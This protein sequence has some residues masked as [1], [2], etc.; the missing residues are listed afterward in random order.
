MAI[1][2]INVREV[3]NKKDSILCNSLGAQCQRVANVALP[4]LAMYKPF[5]FAMG[6]GSGAMKVFA[7]V[8]N[9]TAAIKSGDKKDITFQ[10]I[11]TA[12]TV[13]SLASTLI[14]HPLGMLI[15]T[16]NDV[17]L[18]TFHMVKFIH[19]GDYQKAAE[20]GFSILSN[21]VYLSVMLGGGLELSIASVALQILSGIYQSRAEFM[22][23]NYLEALGHVAM[24]GIKSHQMA[25]QIQTLQS[26]WKFDALL[27]ELSEKQKA[28]EAKPKPTKKMLACVQSKALKNRPDIPE[29]VLNI[30][31]K[32]QQKNTSLLNYLKNYGTECT[33]DDVL[34]LFKHHL[35][36]PDE[37]GKICLELM[38]RNCS[39]ELIQISLPDQEFLA[40]NSSFY[41]EIYQMSLKKHC[42]SK[43]VRLFVS[44]YRSIRDCKTRDQYFL[45][46]YNYEIQAI[47]ANPG[48]CFADF[49]KS[50]RYDNT[51]LH[52]CIKKM[53][54]E[55]KR[56]F[57]LKE[58]SYID[59]KVISSFDECPRPE[60]HYTRISH[61]NRMENILKYN[62][63]RPTVRS[64][65]I[66]LNM[67]PNIHEQAFNNNDLSRE[68]EAWNKLFHSIFP[69]NLILDNLKKE[70][71]ELLAQWVL[72][73][74]SSGR[75]NELRA[76]E[77]NKVINF[78]IEKGIDIKQICSKFS[79]PSF[80][81]EYLK[82]HGFID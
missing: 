62:I 5:G 54:A 73:L 52:N 77:V 29:N 71:M 45:D 65:E 27:K 35:C 40:R 80:S 22:K 1:N 66:L 17:A 36:R 23:G 3:D 8:S 63:G 81:K 16:V 37:E 79:M 4:F 21:A 57:S 39:L 30:Y 34:L 69:D 32:F 58:G 38:K 70:R 60:S 76:V 14:T 31:R 49:I 7:N 24:A 43:E 47:G 78:L 25:G 13:A 18:D 68:I 55:V 61:L 28:Q 56:L 48:E 42:V 26:K 20:K 50:N 11:Q 19:S 10:A 51:V 2:V 67:F 41:D 9:L 64:V 6:V 59:I 75:I 44:D 53:P 46:W 72:S 12:I 33:S 15:T 82:K 74:T